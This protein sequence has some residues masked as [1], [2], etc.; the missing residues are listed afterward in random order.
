MVCLMIVPFL[1]RSS[2][3]GLLGVS[4]I[5]AL[6]GTSLYFGLRICPASA[7]WLPQN[8]ELLVT[9]PLAWTQGGAQ[10]YS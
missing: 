10:P 9:V 2:Y 5:F 1:E 3:L 4:I 6:N 8:M 7:E